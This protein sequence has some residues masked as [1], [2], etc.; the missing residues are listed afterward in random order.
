[1]ADRHLTFDVLLLI[2]NSRFCM[3]MNYYLQSH[4]DIITF[5]YCVSA[6]GNP[7]RHMDIHSGG[8]M[9]QTTA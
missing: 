2:C 7:V 9:K 8:G 3:K 5:V 6:V 1:M 4:K